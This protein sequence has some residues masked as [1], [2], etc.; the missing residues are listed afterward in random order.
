[1]NLGC[2]FGLG[3]RGASPPHGR[4]SHRA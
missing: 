1:V 3:C 2:P 4:S